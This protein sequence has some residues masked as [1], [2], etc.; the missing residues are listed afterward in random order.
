[1]LKLR[2]F[3]RK[4]ANHSTNLEYR[5]PSTAWK[6]A[7]NVGYMVAG[8]IIGSYMTN[9]Y[10]DAIHMSL[11]DINRSIVSGHRRTKQ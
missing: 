4:I 3:V 6:I 11:E 2:T 10:N 5:R 9:C 7:N 1:M 8:V